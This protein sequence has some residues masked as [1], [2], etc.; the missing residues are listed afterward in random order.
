V[1][2]VGFDGNSKKWNLT[3]YVPD[4][5]DKRH[6]SK[7]HLRARAILRKLFPRDRILEE[8]SLPGSN[9]Q[10][11]K[12]LLYADFF[13]PSHKLVIEVHGQQHY[14]FVPFYHKTKGEY[15]RSRKRD[16]D[17]IDWCEMNSLRIVVLKYSESD[18][19]WTRKINGV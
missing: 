4:K 10:S 13:I 14:E 2:I 19:V 11:R 1:K 15:Y 9:T 12:S 17:K 7:N 3:K 16:R 5:D 18:D 6:R 8:V